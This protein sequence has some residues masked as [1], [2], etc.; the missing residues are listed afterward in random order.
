MFRQEIVALKEIVDFMSNSN[1][2]LSSSHGMERSVTIKPRF[3]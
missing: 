3:S 2:S 1:F